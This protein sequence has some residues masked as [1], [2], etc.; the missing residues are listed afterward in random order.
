MKTIYLDF[1]ATTPILP[2]IANAMTPYLYNIFG[3]PSSL[4]KYGIEARKAIETA[5]K[6]TANIINA[7]PY[8]IIFTSGGTESNNIAIMGYC[9]MNKN[10]GN[11]IISSAIEHPAVLE[12]LEH[13]KQYGFYYTLL[14]P[15]RW[16]RISSKD[17]DNAITENTILIT[18]MHSN[19]ETGSLQ[20]ID[21]IG[22]TA[23]SKGIAF[24]TDAAQSVGKIPVDI[25]RS[26]ID[27]LSIAGHKL[28][29]PKG[30]GAL[31]IRKGINVKNIMYGANH[32]KGLRPGTENLLEIAGLGKACEIMARDLDKNRKKMKE[33]RD[34]LYENLKEVKDHLLINDLENSLPNTLSIAFKDIS[35]NRLISLCEDIA[36]SA[37]SACH[38]DI[39]EASYVL[40]AMDIPKEY[41][42]GTLRISTGIINDKQEIIKACGIIKDAIAFLRKEKIQVDTKSIKLTSHSEHLGCSCKI[43]QNILQGIVKNFIIKPDDRILIANDTSDDSA[44]YKISEDHAIVQSLDFFTPI[45]DD[46]YYF[47]QIACAN[48]LSDIYAMGAKPLF[49]LNILCY[50]ISKLPLE[51][52]QSI[53]EG[54]YNKG[55]EAGISIIGGHS[56]ED[57]EI[58]YGLAVSGIIDPKKIIKNNTPKDGDILVLTKPIGTGILCAGMKRGLIDEDI[59]K[60]TLDLMSELNDKPLGIFSNFHINACTDIT[61]FGLLGHLYEMIQGSGLQADLIMEDIPVIQSVYDICSNDLIPKKTKN[62]LSNLHDKLIFEDEI[63]D[64]DKYILSDAQT[65]GGLLFSLSSDHTPQLLDFCRSSN[66]YCR[67]IGNIYKN[68]NGKIRVLR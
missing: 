45:V 33:L 29:A 3:N 14:K 38:A 61:G 40:S 13:L 43:D 20:P 4:H 25:K 5:R 1:N 32:E 35:A 56:I 21:E 19:N 12:V 30:I 7:K 18:I 54:A 6:N 57:E 36:V 53:L 17:L 51:T 64:T 23:K 15:D 59:K 2:E 47:G 67:V 52:L 66:I 16:G 37:G 58:K 65:S 62:N 41:I 31:Y 63:T 48:A 44:V 46:P 27:M 55:K 22:K 24:H 60:Y 34:L 10:K 42:M 26:N 68:G 50:P 39:E 8:E 11:H 49:G 9:L 28:Y